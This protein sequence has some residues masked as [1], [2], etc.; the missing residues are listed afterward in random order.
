[1]ISEWF[2]PELIY[3]IT[4]VHYLAAILHKKFKEQG[5]A[6][7]FFVRYIMGSF[8]LILAIH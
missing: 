5:D 4:S 3:V 2:L 8:I 6:Y 7:V 1:M